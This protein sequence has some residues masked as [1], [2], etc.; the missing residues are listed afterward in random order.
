MITT[1]PGLIMPIAT[2]IRNCAL[3]EPA[4]LLH[5][6]LLE[7][8]HDHEAAAESE[9]AGLEEEQQKLAELELDGDRRASPTGSQR[10]QRS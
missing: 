5:Q 10:E 8:R 2:A 3:I 9:R 6:P 7:E 4:V 1:G